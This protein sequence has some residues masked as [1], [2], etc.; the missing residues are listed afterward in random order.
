MIMREAYRRDGPMAMNQWRRAKEFPANSPLSF[1][2]KWRKLMLAC[3]A[4]SEVPQD[5]GLAEQSS[6]YR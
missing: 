1:Q 3:S 4:E 5:N 2:A 6:P